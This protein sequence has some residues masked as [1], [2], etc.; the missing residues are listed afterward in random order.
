MGAGDVVVACGQGMGVG[1]LLAGI[2]VISAAI[3]LLRKKRRK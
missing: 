3:V 2:V 1:L